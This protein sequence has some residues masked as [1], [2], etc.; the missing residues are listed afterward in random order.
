MVEKDCLGMVFG[1]LFLKIKRR[2]EEKMEKYLKFIFIV[3]FTISAFF[4]FCNNSNGEEISMV[5][6]K[7]ITKVMLALKD[8]TIKYSR[9]NGSM[10]DYREIEQAFKDALEKSNLTEA[11]SSSAFVFVLPD[12]DISEKKTYVLVGDKRLVDSDEEFRVRVKYLYGRAVRGASG[13]SKL[14]A[15]ALSK[16]DHRIYGVMLEVRYETYI[17]TEWNKAFEILYFKGRI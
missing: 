7:E 14:R 11:F 16:G 15:Y 13:K 17:E 6:Q 2:R 1:C 12:R 4:A 8:V 5:K 9:A 10:P 3:V